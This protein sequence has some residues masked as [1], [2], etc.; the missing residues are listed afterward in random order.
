MR[1]VTSGQMKKIEENAL[2]YALSYERMMENAGSAAAAAIRRRA[3]I[4]GR[5][6]TISAAAAIMEE[7]GL[8]PHAGCMKAARM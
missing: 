5:Y 3:D 1:I 7:T 8:S 6:I 4:S 2:H